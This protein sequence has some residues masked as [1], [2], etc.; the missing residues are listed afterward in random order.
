MSTVEETSHRSRLSSLG[1][2]SDRSVSVSVG[3]RN[4]R[5]YEH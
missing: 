4:E 2:G 5:A 3:V 1:S